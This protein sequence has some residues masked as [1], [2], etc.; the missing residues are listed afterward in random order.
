MPQTWGLFLTANG[1][2]FPP[3]TFPDFLY[4]EKFDEGT[5]NR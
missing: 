4:P 2:L 5:T 3:E 1:S